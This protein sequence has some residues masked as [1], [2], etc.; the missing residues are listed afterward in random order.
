MQKK[1][2]LKIVE[3]DKE[4]IIKSRTYGF[5]FIKENNMKEQILSDL[6]MAMKN[7]DKER[8]SVIRML[9]GAIQMEELNTKKELQDDDIIG[10]VSKQIKTRKESI[11]E[12]EKGNRQDLIDKTESEIKILEKY[13]PE[14]MS[15]EEILD[16]IQKAFDSIKPTSPSD[17]G[18]LM[19]YLTPIFKGKAD[20]GMV[21][22]MIRERLSKMNEEV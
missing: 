13:M 9:K 4:N 20:M 15:E 12:F 17:M 5:L 11:Q 22:K 6:K 10:I 16:E 19:G 7:Q 3:E 18:K 2:Q 8:L 14:P 1:K 21:S